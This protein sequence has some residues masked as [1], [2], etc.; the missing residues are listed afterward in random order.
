MSYGIACFIAQRST[1][2]F[3]F[4]GAIDVLISRPEVGKW[5]AAPPRWVKAVKESPETSWVVETLNPHQVFPY[6]WGASI[7]S[8]FFPSGAEGIFLARCGGQWGRGSN[9]PPTHPTW[10]S[11]R[12]LEAGEG[13][14]SLC[15]QA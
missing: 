10:P 14:E 5:G 3:C 9:Y 8:Q 2:I 6:F 11:H 1:L 15:P 4:F 13:G 7:I 12:A